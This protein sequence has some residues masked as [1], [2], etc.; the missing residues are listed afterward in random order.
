MADLRAFL[1][2]SKQVSEQP[3]Y[4]V[5]PAGK[6]LATIIDSEMMANKAGTGRYLKLTFRLAEGQHR[7]RL[8]WTR[9]NL[10]HPNPTV[11]SIARTELALLCKAVGVSAPNDSSELH[12]RPLVIQVKCRKRQDTGEIVNEIRGYFPAQASEPTQANKVAP[13]ASGGTNAQTPLT[14]DEDIPW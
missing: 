2:D 14:S 3:G 4:N 12:G 11:V 13:Q 8:L 9:L 10:D 1:G 7:G 5:I 6:Y